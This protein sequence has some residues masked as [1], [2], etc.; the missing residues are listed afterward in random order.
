MFSFLN[1]WA[2][3]GVL[4]L[5]APLSAFSQVTIGIGLVNFGRVFHNRTQ[6]WLWVKEETA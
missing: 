6:G 2:A 4:A 5:A 3:L 1:R